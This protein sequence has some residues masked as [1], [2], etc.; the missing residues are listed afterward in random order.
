MFI[1]E[2]ICSWKLW[3]LW[4]WISCGSRFWS[5]SKSKKWRINQVDRF[6]FFLQKYVQT[7]SLSFTVFF[8]WNYSPGP[9]SGLFRGKPPSTT[10]SEPEI[11]VWNLKG[12]NYSFLWK[13]IFCKAIK[14]L[15]LSQWKSC[16]DEVDDWAQHNQEKKLHQIIYNFFKN[17]FSNL[18]S[19]LAGNIVLEMGG[20]FK[21]Y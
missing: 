12:S 14:I 3:S 1:V 11:K 16:F 13:Q 10:S 4:R 17:N 8:S 19:N 2:K 9:K 18:L 5:H 15:L 20:Y 21:L 7:W 6:E